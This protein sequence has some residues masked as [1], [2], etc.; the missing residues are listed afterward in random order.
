MKTERLQVDLESTSDWNE[1][2]NMGLGVVVDPMVFRSGE[3]F[4]KGS[5]G[6]YSSKDANW[7][8]LSHNL[9]SIGAFFDALILNEKI[10][11]FDYGHSFLGDCSFYEMVLTKINDYDDVLFNVHVGMEPYHEIKK[12][13]LA[14]LERMPFHPRSLPREL[15]E[16]VLNELST[17]EYSWNP[18]LQ[19]LE[20]GFVTEE[21][22]RIARFLLGG[23]VFGGY[24]Q[25]MEGEHVIQAKRSR[26][27]LALALQKNSCEPGLE[28]AF[29]SQL[30]E[31]AN[32]PCGE[33][34]W[35][36][37]FFPHL[38][39]KTNKPLDILEE[40]A[41]LRNSPEVRDYRQW[42][43]ELMRDFRNGK[44]SLEKKR[45]IK[46][47]E[48]SIGRMLDLKTSAPKIEAKV[49]MAG[50]G[51]PKAVLS[52]DLTDPFQK[53]WGWGLSA[54]PGKRHIKLLT[55]VIIAESEYTQLAMK[56]RNVWV[57][58]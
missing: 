39:N 1:L 45:D 54:L 46:L 51:M 22:K 52:V 38:L 21:E 56:V 35:R 55:R 31:R 50:I 19:D 43:G 23:L 4:L 2:R 17:V 36:P 7:D 37:T 5:S 15:V 30:M 58:G 13:A 53:L 25:Q 14:E 12:A 28:E 6:S 3:I 8:V 42:M 34:P 24:A 26:L 18:S 11:V 9:H 10:P 49:T 27:F 20:N 33:L 32:F 29:F 48:E 41:K 47:I 44:T 16:G 40:V 57:A